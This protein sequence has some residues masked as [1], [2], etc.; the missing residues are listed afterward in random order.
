MGNMYFG[1][2]DPALRAVTDADGRY[3]VAKIPAGP[4]WVSAREPKGRS[5]SQ[6]LDL[7]A[8]QDLTVFS[9]IKGMDAIGGGMAEWASR[10]RTG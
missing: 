7:S 6:T 1:L 5:A 4:V 9:R 8:G 10:D 2:A 3:A